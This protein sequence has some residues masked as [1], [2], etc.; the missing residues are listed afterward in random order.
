MHVHSVWLGLLLLLL[1][2]T[3]IFESL[4]GMA[5]NSIGALRFSTW[6][7]ISFVANAFQSTPGPTLAKEATDCLT[8]HHSFPSPHK[9]DFS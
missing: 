6:A 5:V 1:L 3:G 2:Q 7:E 9:I 8:F 4:D